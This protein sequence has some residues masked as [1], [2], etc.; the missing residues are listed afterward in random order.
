MRNPMTIAMIVSGF[1]FGAVALGQQG[2][3]GRMDQPN[4]AIER[5]IST[6]LDGEEIKSVLTPGE[7]SEYPLTLRKGQVVIAEARSD[8]FDPA[9]EVV[10]DKGRVLASNDDRYPGDQR[11]LLL[12]RC[13]RAGA[14]AIH[15]RCFH[16]K[17]GGQFYLRLKVY[18]SVDLGSDKTVEQEVTNPDRFLLRI[19]MKA[20]QIRQ[21]IPEP[22]TEG[23]WLQGTI[24]PT[25]LPDID[26]AQPIG[27]VIHNTILA[28]VDGDYY[29]IATGRR[30][31]RRIRVG[32]RLIS[33]NALVEQ[34]GEC[35]AVAG[36]NAPALWTLS[37][38]AGELLKASTPGLP[39]SSPLI[40]V[41]EPDIS[42]FD[43]KK[44]ETNP[45]FP[46]TKSGEPDKVPSLIGLAGRA[47]DPRVVVF[48]VK[49]DAKI[50]LATNSEGLPNKQFT[51]SV[52]PAPKTFVE[53]SGSAASLG[54]GNTDY[55]SFEAKVGDV[56]TFDSQ[57]ASFAAHLQLLD[58]DLYENWSAD[59]AP[60][61]T[62]ADW[63]MIVQ[64]PGR[65][66]V[67]VSSIG[68]GGGGEYRLNRKVFH[69]KEFGKGSPAKGDF[70]DGQVHVWRFTAKPEEPL[71]LHWKSSDWS[72]S[73]SIRTDDGALASLPLTLVDGSNQYG[74][75]KVEKPNTFLIVL[76]P[77]QSKA[78]YSIEL[79]DLPGYRGSAPRS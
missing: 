63:D 36:T 7:F 9:L 25:G 30:D 1:C 17:S 70:S 31:Q 74:I 35:S 50:W 71:Y 55:W 18:D 76:M 45:F 65:Y 26:L 16:D 5:R 20:G 12:W 47:R 3:I 38:K 24:S 22:P 28:P 15:A 8:A 44:P 68:N 33:T 23:L 37:V 64:K 79:S 34:S 62:S 27:L 77:K 14:Y 29:V 10:D 19:P 54:I 73:S 32:T 2:Q 13:D 61:Q 67:A 66:L 39:L 48:L 51:L 56:M 43:L 41:E 21:V 42:K 46:K 60:D 11:P 59:M 78:T 75:L 69:A 53:A 52:Q 57:A 4:A 72:Y 6:Y 58:P 49:R 40:V